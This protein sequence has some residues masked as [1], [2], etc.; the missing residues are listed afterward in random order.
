MDCSI[1]TTT[2]RAR[3]TF[4]AKGMIA[5]PICSR[6]SPHA[7]FNCWMGPSPTFAAAAACPPNF[8]SSSSRIIDC[9]LATSPVCANFLMTSVCSFVKVMPA[10]DSDESFVTGSL[11]ALPNCNDAEPKS[12]SNAVARSNAKACVRLKFS[13]VMFVKA[14]RRAVDLSRMISSPKSVRPCNSEA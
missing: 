13:P 8:F 5:A 6:K 12:I 10:R 2:I 14:N 4:V 11:R 3:D 7:F 1:V 9:A